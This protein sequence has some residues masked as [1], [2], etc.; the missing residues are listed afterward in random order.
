LLD[1]R[2]R[3]RDLRRRRGIEAGKPI[4]KGIPAVAAEIL[5]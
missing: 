2:Q 3:D 1:A 4:L 5:A